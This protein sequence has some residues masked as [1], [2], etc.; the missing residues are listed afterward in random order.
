[1][2]LPSPHVLQF[3]LA[4]SLWDGAASSTRAS[5]EALAC[6]PRVHHESTGIGAVAAT[7]SSPS[8]LFPP[9]VLQKRILLLVFHTL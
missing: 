4:K 1:M 3:D 7:D 9:H 6:L 2:L 5:G 8:M